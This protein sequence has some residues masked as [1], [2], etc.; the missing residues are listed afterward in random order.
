[1]RILVVAAHPDDEILGPGGTII[2]HVAAG[3]DV[4]VYIACAGTNIRYEAPQAAEL[5]DTARRVGGLLGTVVRL[6]ELPD[7]ALDTLPLTR[8]VSALG[9]EIAAADPDL[10][11]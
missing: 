9:G 11:Y 4:T 5:Y 1:M 3:D 6:G 7:Q 2:R 8:V 10:V